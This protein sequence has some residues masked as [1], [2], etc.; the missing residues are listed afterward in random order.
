MIIRILLNTAANSLGLTIA[1][2]ARI[3]Y[4]IYFKGVI[5]GSACQASAL[6]PVQKAD[7]LL[8]RV[9]Y[10]RKTR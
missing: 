8:R 3:I 9:T 2:P 7:L 6:S 1:F 10:E 5:G 4:F